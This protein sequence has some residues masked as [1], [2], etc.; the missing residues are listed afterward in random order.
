MVMAGLLGIDH[1][2]VAVRDIEAVRGRYVALGF[3]MT[4]VSHH[5]WGTSTSAAVFRDC[6]LELMGIYDE[7]LIDLFPAGDFR[8]GRTVRDH[9]AER[10]GISLLA[11]NSVDADA[12]V[13]TV[14]ERGIACQG[15]I[16]FGRDIT[17]PDGRPDRTS[18][19]LRIIHDPDLPRLSNF[20]CQQHRRDLIEVP[21]WLEHPNGATGICQVT[22]MASE[23]DQ[24]RV[25]TRMAR[26]YG[27]QAIATQ[28]HGFSV[29]TGNG[30]FVILTAAAVEDAY[31]SMPPGLAS[32]TRPC[33]IAIHVRVPAI[34]GVLPFLDAGNVSRTLR[35]GRLVVE[36]PG[37]YGNV[38]L[39]FDAAPIN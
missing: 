34:D 10:E 20:V 2:L 27:E 23:Q 13:R 39:V 12:D 7:G 15:G 35:G 4:P 24:P 30:S 37:A 1:P 19:S 5:P 17:L 33:W 6:L 38:L 29:R 31:G 9:L 14:G 3:V 16:E 8:F 36:P 28:D 21:K 18:T 22:V 25:R 26:L 11:L 32:E